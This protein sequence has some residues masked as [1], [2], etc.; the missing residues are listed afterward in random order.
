MD[1]N[2]KSGE[3]RQL[4]QTLKDAQE[5]LIKEMKLSEEAKQKVD[6]LTVSSTFLLYIRY[7]AKQ[8]M[9]KLPKP[10]GSAFVYIG[11]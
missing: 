4:I 7:V 9:H 1:N 2:R 5:A 6:S 3:T 8:S 11:L 10:V